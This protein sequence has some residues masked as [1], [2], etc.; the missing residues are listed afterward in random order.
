[1]ASLPFIKIPTPNVNL[2]LGAALTAD[3]CA[4]TST[5]ADGKGHHSKKFFL[6][7]WNEI[8]AS[9]ICWKKIVQKIRLDPYRCIV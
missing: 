1:M 6:I 9:G 8:E 7:H 3:G 5:A 2:Q 4:A